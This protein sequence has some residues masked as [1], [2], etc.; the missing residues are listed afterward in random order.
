MAKKLLYPE[1]EEGIRIQYKDRNEATRQ[2]C[3]VARKGSTI[4]VLGALKT[5]ARVSI[6]NIT[7][8]WQPKVKAS[9]KNFIKLK[10]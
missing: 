3:I 7:G 10:K 8:Y 9:P 4:S 5:K 1:L 2:G 6:G